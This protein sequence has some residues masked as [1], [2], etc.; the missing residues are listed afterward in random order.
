MNGI[1]TKQPEISQKTNQCI[2]EYSRGTYRKVK[3]GEHGGVN[4]RSQNDH[5]RGITVSMTSHPLA[6]VFQANLR[7]QVMPN[8]C[9]NDS[10]EDQIRL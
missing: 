4:R 3:E 9:P 7:E 6:I 8:A 5:E 2:R 10:R 1:H